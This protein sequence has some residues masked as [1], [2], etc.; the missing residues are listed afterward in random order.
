MFSMAPFASAQTTTN[1]TTAAELLGTA[2]QLHAAEAK[3]NEARTA[4]IAETASQDQAQHAQP[5]GIFSFSSPALWILFAILIGLLLLLFAVRRSVQEAVIAGPEVLKKP[6][7]PMTGVLPAVRPTAERPLV[8]P[9][10]VVKIKVRKL[11]KSI[12]R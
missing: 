8:Q 5:V 11:P 1:T 7:Q 12:K 4:L 9:V 3:V 2:A 6:I 10:K